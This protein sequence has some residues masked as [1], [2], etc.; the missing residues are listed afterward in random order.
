MTQLGRSMLEM[1]AVLAIMGAL[2]I[3]GL[4][5][6]VQARTSGQAIHIASEVSYA[7]KE[8]VLR[9]DWRGLSAGSSYKLSDVDILNI[10]IETPYRFTM[11]TQVPWK[12][13][14]AVLPKLEKTHT[15]HANDALFT[16]S[17]D[18]CGN[19]EDVTVSFTYT[20]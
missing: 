2:S 1:L 11:T 19:Q 20:E 18:I 3:G 8:M 9:D 14:R 4:W 6:L 17:T 13:C 15:I 12:V 10:T 5:G 16:G 7:T